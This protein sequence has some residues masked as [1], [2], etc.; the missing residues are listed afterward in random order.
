MM[1]ERKASK[2]YNYLFE[3]LPFPVTPKDLYLTPCFKN[4]PVATLSLAIYVSC[5]KLEHHQILANSLLRHTV[6]LLPEL[7]FC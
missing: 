1:K 4:T 2:L 6:L 5:H 3:L 7:E